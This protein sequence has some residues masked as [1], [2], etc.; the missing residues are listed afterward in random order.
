MCDQPRL[1]HM[2]ACI[3]AT[4]VGVHPLNM[5]LNLGAFNEW[6]SQSGLSYEVY[7][8]RFIRQFMGHAYPKTNSEHVNMTLFVDAHVD[9]YPPGTEKWKLQ[10]N[11]DVGKCGSR[12]TLNFKGSPCAF[13]SCH[14]VRN[15][16]PLLEG[17]EARIGNECRLTNCYNIKARWPV[18]EDEHWTD[19]WKHEGNSFG[20]IKFQTLDYDPFRTWESSDP[21]Y[22]SHDDIH[23]FGVLCPSASNVK[24]DEQRRCKLEYSRDSCTLGY[25]L[26]AEHHNS[27]ITCPA[28]VAYLARLLHGSIGGPVC[29][30]IDT[31]IYGYLFG[32]L[33]EGWSYANDSGAFWGNDQCNVGKI[34][35]FMRCGDTN[36]RGENP[37][38]Y[39]INSLPC[40]QSQALNFTVEI[41]DL[42]LYRQWFSKD[43]KSI[44]KVDYMMATLDSDNGRKYIINRCGD[45]RDSK[46]RYELYNRDMRFKREDFS[47]NVLDSMHDIYIAGK[48]V[49]SIKE[50]TSPTF[51]RLIK[52]WVR[53]DFREMPTILTLPLDIEIITVTEATT[54]TANQIP[55]SII[56]SATVST[57]V[58]AVSA[59][60]TGSPIPT[61]SASVSSDITPS[62]QSSTASG[63]VHPPG[64]GE[65]IENP[66]TVT[67]TVSG[68]GITSTDK[69]A[70]AST[71]SVSSAV[72]LRS[73]LAKFLTLV[74]GT[75]MFLFCY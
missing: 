49:D 30:D 17:D 13:T 7:V 54:T 29:S 37:W 25:H 9:K 44:T 67:S 23:K 57:T 60:S 3:L 68:P 43:W 58:S 26:W 8:D 64:D 18:P 70:G 42:N 41:E 62:V 63:T 4:L 27:T 21:G 52:N 59:A 66:P 33:T 71:D 40:D 65:I 48:M 55:T 16:V 39:E 10:P 2:T 31:A 36:S 56:P 19:K 74:I 1:L 72:A 50:A 47:K 32:H 73:Y 51:H 38:R 11:R 6:H 12:Q 24:I 15:Q 22:Y 5:T 53:H 14:S 45:S 34:E 61:T 69:P 46:L 28:V 20:Y 35:K 75:V